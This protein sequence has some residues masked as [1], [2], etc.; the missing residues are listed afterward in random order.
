MRKS[1]AIIIATVAAAVAIA[2]PA[3]AQNYPL[4]V[5][6]TMN[7]WNAAGNVMTLQSGT[8]GSTAIWSVDLTGVAAGHQEFKITEGDW[9]WSVPSSG[10]A[11][12]NQDGS[13]NITLTYD[14]N[15]YADGWSPATGR[16]GITAA[17]DPGTWQAVGDWMS[18]NVAELGAGNWNNSDATDDMTALGGG[19]YEYTTQ[20]ATPGSYNYKAVQDGSWNAIGSDGRSINANNLGF[21]TTDPNQT[22]EFEVNAL[23]GTIIVVPE[24][25]TLALV[26]VG[27][28]G[29]LAIRRRKV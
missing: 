18:Q 19:I 11:W 29:A 7:G 8:P 2:A 26:G 1:F 15:T 24:P 4:Y 3:M 5:A 6:G 25:T 20:I 17:G 14:Q 16:Y 13:G 12:F 27:L 22:V 9:N 10:N 28:L 21:T 23:N